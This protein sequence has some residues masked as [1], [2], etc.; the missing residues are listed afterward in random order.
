MGAFRPPR[1]FQVPKR[2]GNPKR[3]F[4]SWLTLR[5][6][7]VLLSVLVLG[8]FAVTH[9]L[10]NVANTDAA[11]IS[12]RWASP[13]WITWDS[14]M[15]AAALLHGGTGLWVVIDDYAAPGVRRI[16]LHGVLVLSGALVF[17]L[18]T[19]TIARSVLGST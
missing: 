15:L 6:T 10:T 1:L 8:H 18:G 11:F 14:L 3:R 7:G 17:V 12:H 5:L 19:V 16:S 4:I 9:I 2:A 13:F